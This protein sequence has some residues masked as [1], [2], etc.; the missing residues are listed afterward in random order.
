MFPAWLRGIF[1]VL[2]SFLFWMFGKITKRKL[3]WFGWAEKWLIEKDEE[4]SETD[5]ESA[6]T[7]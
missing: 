3:W 4:A 5:L 6:V 1:V 2:G 7:S